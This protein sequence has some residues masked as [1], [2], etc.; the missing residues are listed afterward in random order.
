MACT[1]QAEKLDVLVIKPLYQQIEPGRVA[2]SNT[3]STYTLIEKSQFENKY[4]NLSA[5]IEHEA[6][7]QTRASGGIGG[8][9]SISLRGASSE[10]VSVYLDGVALNQASG[11]SVD[12]SLISLDEVERIEVFRGTVPIELSHASLGGA[13]NIISKKSATN[14]QS[15]KA[16]LASFN[17]QA[18]NYSKHITGNKSRFFFSASAL[19]SDNDF[20]FTNNNGTPLNSTDD[21]REKRFNNK[22]AQYSIMSG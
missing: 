20:E 7:V 5:L 10:Q 6:G 19:K 2:L 1:A 18:Y 15:L 9:S 17:T 13:V 16:S 21:R 11:G 3:T 12:L 4:Q 22:L 14:L 8:F